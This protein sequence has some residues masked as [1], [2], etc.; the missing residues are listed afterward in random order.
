MVSTAI[1]LLLVICCS[2]I[3]FNDIREHRIYNWHLLILLLLLAYN[4]KYSSLFTSVVAIVGIWT[5]SIACNIGGGDAKL[6]SLLVIFQGQSLLTVRYF[7]LVLISS[8]LSLL[9]YLLHKRTLQGSLPLA[10][11]ILLPFI[12]IYLNI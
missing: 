2:V 9:V 3:I 7:S 4:A 11:A 10:P 5:L 8:S 12:A 6:L 1:S